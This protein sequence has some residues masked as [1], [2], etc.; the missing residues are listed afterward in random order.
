V[1][2]KNW[3][4]QILTYHNGRLV[5]DA[6]LSDLSHNLQK[7]ITF[8]IVNHLQNLANGLWAVDNGDK[9]FENLPENEP[10]IEDWTDD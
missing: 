4:N 5:I 10:H 1:T 2:I 3:I 9:I 6:D 7:K 8:E